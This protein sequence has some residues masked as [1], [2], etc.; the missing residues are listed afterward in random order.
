MMKTTIRPHLP[1][2]LLARIRETYA[3][4]VAARGSSFQTIC[5]ALIDMRATQKLRG[6]TPGSVAPGILNRDRFVAMLRC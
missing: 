3:F 1:T 5:A 4:C 2:T 6:T